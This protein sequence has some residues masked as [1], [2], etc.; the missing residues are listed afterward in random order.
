M[1][2]YNLAAG[3]FILVGDLNFHLDSENDYNAN[4]FMDII[5]SLNFKQLVTAPTHNHGHILDVVIT[6]EDDDLIQEVTVLDMVSDHCL[7]KC[8]LGIPKLPPISKTITVR[9]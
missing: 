8:S 7:I 9:K 6:R 2:N 1:Q 4:R 3:A 5:T